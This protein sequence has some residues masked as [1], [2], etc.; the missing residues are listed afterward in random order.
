MSIS[1]STT[2][3]NG[4]YTNGRQLDAQFDWTYNG[5]T[6]TYDDSRII[7]FNVVE[8]ISTLN[9]TVPSDQ[10]TL[11]IDNTDGAFNFL[12]LQNMQSIIGSRP[13]IALRCGLNEVNTPGD[14]WNVN[15]LNKVSAST[16]EN[17]N[18]AKYGRSAS[19]LTPSGSWTSELTQAYYNQIMTS[20]NSDFTS[21]STATSGYIAQTLFQF[22]IIRLLQDK[23]GV[24]IWQGKTLL[25]DK[26]ALAQT[27]INT[28]T[29]N[30]TGYGTAPSAN[31]GN[32][33]TVST[34]NNSWVTGVNH[35][36]ATNTKL[37]L[38]I[39]DT[40]IDSNGFIN[41]LVYTNASD[42]TTQSIV[43]TDYIE[44]NIITN[45]IDVD[46]WINMGT[47]Y[48]DAW[49]NNIQSVVL[50]AHDNLT[51]LANT[52]YIPP[53]PASQ[54]LYALAQNIFSQAGITNYNLDNALNN[55]TTNGF[56]PIT[57]N[58]QTL[59]CR[60]A[61]QHVAIAGQCTLY[62][63]RNGV[64][65]IKS[66]GTL[67]SASLYSNYPT[68]TTKGT[69]MASLWGYPVANTASSTSPPTPI[70]SNFI[71]ENTDSGMR[72][73]GLV[74]M[75]DLPV[76]T[77]DNSIYQLVVNV[78]DGSFNKTQQTYTN[79]SMTTNGNGQSFTIDNPLINSNTQ[80]Q[81]VANWFFT[82]S[83]YN[84]VYQANWRQNP[85]LVSTDVVVVENGH[86]DGNGGVVVD[87]VKQSR[88]YK[89][90]FNYSGYLSGTTETRG[91]L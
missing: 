89:Q 41:V 87:T 23:Y 28:L 3:K 22:D 21:G 16:T 67:D 45:A 65:Q 88:I 44:L 30:W 17:G 51:F 53:T 63:D 20:D 69:G 32:K 91:G 90:E 58:S 47:F 81:S 24:G 62:Q 19:I 10:L 74:N 15:F 37:S 14:N 2:Y 60:D 33:A 77:L 11:T 12:N 42:G 9:D 49:K 68:S 80:A 79:P 86:P 25:S 40:Y 43:Y 56:Q 1:T 57:T 52:A 35:T 29:C 73:I 7:S 5:T 71:N 66:F 54:T 18:I 61:L 78:Y 26:I 38:T 70:N 50:T 64:M 31:G 82:E 76:I 39:P 83:N 59:S 48:V 75:Y 72:Y 8:E 13:T 34:W 55:V 27:Y 46:E 6:T 4:I 36:N 85:C 84:A